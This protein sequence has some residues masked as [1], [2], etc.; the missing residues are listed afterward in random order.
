MP[1]DDKH[2]DSEY[3]FDQNDD[4]DDNESTKLLIE[5]SSE[6][7]TDDEQENLDTFS[8]QQWPQSYK[9]LSFSACS[10]LIEIL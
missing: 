10:F 9:S 6:S 8:S 4:D 2:K 1:G 5:G 7:G 3:F